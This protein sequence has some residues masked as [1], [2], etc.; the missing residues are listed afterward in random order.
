MPSVQKSAPEIL[1][2]KVELMTGIEPVS[3]IL[4][5]DALYLL[6]Y[7]SNLLTTVVLYNRPYFFA[8]VL[9]IFFAERIGIKRWM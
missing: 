8:S 1:R 5:K 2:G 3:L 9:L 7:I 6:S 4:T